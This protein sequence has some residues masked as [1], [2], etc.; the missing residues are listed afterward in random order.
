MKTKI[1]VIVGM[2]ILT[3]IFMRGCIFCLFREITFK[4]EESNLVGT[5][6]SDRDEVLELRKDHIAVGHGLHLFYDTFDLQ[7]NI[8]PPDGAKGEWY[9]QESQGTWILGIKWEA[10]GTFKAAYTFIMILDYPPHTLFKGLT[11]DPDSY[12]GIWLTC[13]RQ[14]RYHGMRKLLIYGPV[15]V[16]ILMTIHYYRRRKK[17]KAKL[18]VFI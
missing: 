7:D 16:V 2:M 18:E 14:N 9:L 13:K 5:W 4:P 3:C 6:V 11:A 10:E 1:Y 15:V 12:D 17:C 8:P